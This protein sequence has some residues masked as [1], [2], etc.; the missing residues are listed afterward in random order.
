L[1]Y[2]TPTY[3][4]GAAYADLDN[5]G[6]LDM[7]T[8]NIDEKHRFGRVMLV[9]WKQDKKPNYLRVALSG[10]QL[11]REGLELRL[12]SEAMELFNITYFSPYRGYLSTV[13]PYLHFGLGPSSNVDSV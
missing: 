7:I 9:S 13:E 8:N 2:W 12:N 6:D 11:N 3:S 10:P 1:G 4:N 5:D